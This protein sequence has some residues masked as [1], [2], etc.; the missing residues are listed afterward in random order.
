MIEFLHLSW[1]FPSIDDPFLLSLYRLPT[2]SGFSHLSLICDHFCSPV[3]DAHC[4]S[5]RQIISHWKN[6]VREDCSV[7]KPMKNIQNT[8]P[9]GPGSGNNASGGADRRQGTVSF[10]ILHGQWNFVAGDMMPTMLSNA[11]GLISTAGGLPN[12]GNMCLDGILGGGGS[13]RGMSDGPSMSMQQQQQM[14]DAAPPDNAM[15]GGVAAGEV[16]M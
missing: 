6:C 15:M 7:C 5:S 2:D 16:T 13:G 12:I 10:L 1:A 9:I 4:A 3:A 8:S 11:T 14:G